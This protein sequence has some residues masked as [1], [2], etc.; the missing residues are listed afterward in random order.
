MKKILY[1]IMLLL[2]TVTMLSSCNKDGDLIYLN[3]FGGSGLTATTNDVVLSIANSKKLVLSM[4]WNN[5]TLLSSDSSKTAPDGVLKTYLQIS[6][7]EDFSGK[8]NE[9]TVISPSKAY[10]GD[11]LNSIAKGL[12]LSADVSA[13]LYF[14]IKSVEGNNM[15]P[16]YSNVEKVNVTPFTIHMNFVSVLSKEKTDTVARLYS[17]SENGVY[18]GYMKAAG[19]YNCWF[20]ENDGTTW[21]NYNVSGHEFELS[22]ASDAWNCWFADGSG[23]WFVTVDTKNEVWSAANITNV[24]INNSNFTYDSKKGVWTAQ[25]TTTADNTQIGGTATGNEYNSTTRTSSSVAKTF[26]LPDTTIAKAGVYTVNMY[27]NS[28]AQYS[29]EIISGTVTPDNP[30][31]KFPSELAMYSKDGSTKLATLA[32]TGTGTYAGTYAAQQWEN[33]QIVDEE[34]KVWYG[35]DPTNQYTLDSADGKYAIWFN[36]D[37]TN[38]TTLNVTVDLN[39]MKWSYTK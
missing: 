23:D 24:T 27:I 22:K 14:R 10:I 34:N 28:H 30:T 4:E 33:F 11:D 15:E 26:N 20:V 2:T 3:G 38:G 39:T 17:D 13:P 36:A 6:A 1:Y 31:V 21:G 29:Y 7:N 32:K 18:T 8:V 37:F 35:S 9:S 25:I 5:P 19:W 12:G 16:A